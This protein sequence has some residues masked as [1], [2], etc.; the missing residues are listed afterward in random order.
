MSDEL[1][2]YILTLNAWD[3]VLIAVAVVLWGYLMYFAIRY[4]DAVARRAKKSNDERPTTNDQ[5]P[6][7]TVVVCARNE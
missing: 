2:T 6:G 7:V 4:L 1:L 5:Q 3:Y